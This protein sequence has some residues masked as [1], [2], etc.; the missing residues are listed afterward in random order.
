MYSELKSTI[1]FVGTGFEVVLEGK[2]LPERG[3]PE[4]SDLADVELDLGLRLVHEQPA[5]EVIE[6]GGREQHGQPEHDDAVQAR[7]GGLHGQHVL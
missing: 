2:L 4:L 3:V 7:R 6:Q 1:Y 5:V